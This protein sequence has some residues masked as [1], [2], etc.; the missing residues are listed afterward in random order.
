MRVVW[1]IGAL[2]LG[3]NGDWVKIQSNKVCT[4]G[5]QLPFIYDLSGGYGTD[6]WD[7]VSAS[8][9]WDSKVTFQKCKHQ[10][11]A[12]P[13]HCTKFMFANTDTDEF[14]MTV[15]GVKKCQ[16]RWQTLT[17]F[18][19]L[20][21][22]CSSYTDD[23]NFDVWE[24]IVDEDDH[25]RDC[26]LNEHAVDGVCTPCPAG[27]A[28]PFISHA[29]KY[30]NWSCN[31][32]YC[33]KDEHVSNGQCVACP[34]GKVRDAGDSALYGNTACDDPSDFCGLNQKSDGTTC[35]PCPAHT[36]WPHSRTLKS[37][38]W[39]CDKVYCPGSTQVVNGDCT[40]CPNKN[41][42]V[43]GVNTTIRTGGPAAWKGGPNT[44]CQDYGEFQCAF[45]QWSDGGTRTCLQCPQ[46]KGWGY[47]IDPARIDLPNGWGCQEK[48]NTWHTNDVEAEDYGT[49]CPSTHQVYNH[50]CFP[51]APG[52]HNSRQSGS[53]SEM[54]RE[55]VKCTPVTCGQNKHVHNHQCVACATNSFNWVG[56][57]DPRGANTACKTAS[58]YCGRNQHASN[59]QCVQCPV[60]THWPH[61]HTSKAT[62]YACQTRTCRKDYFFE[63][64]GCTQCWPFTIT[65]PLNKGTS[66]GALACA[67]NQYMEGHGCKN[68]P[69]GY[70]C[71]GK[72]KNVKMCPFHHKVVSHACVKCQ[73][74]SYN[75]KNERATSSMNTDCTTMT[76]AELAT[77]T[78]SPRHDQSF[79]GYD[80]RM[81]FKNLYYP[82]WWK[83]MY[84]HSHMRATADASVKAELAEA[85]RQTAHPTCEN[86]M[87]VT[88]AETDTTL[89]VKG[90]PAD[91][92]ADDFMDDANRGNQMKRFLTTVT[93]RTVE[94]NMFKIRSTR[95]ATAMF[96]AIEP[97]MHKECH[98]HSGLLRE[99]W[100]SDSQTCAGAF[101]DFQTTFGTSGCEGDRER[102]CC[103]TC[104]SKKS[105][106]GQLVHKL[107]SMSVAVQ[108]LAGV[109]CLLLAIAMGYGVYYY[110][111]TDGNSELVSDEERK[112]FENLP[113]D[114]HPVESRQKA[115]ELDEQ[116][117][118]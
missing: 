18:T 63:N 4:S 80:V 86:E 34:T 38:T 70:S 31:P 61:D 9:V 36:E 96:M 66:C 115:Y 67:S 104:L 68:C 39:T 112:S 92:D 65:G 64:N 88:M 113:S 45:N 30:P 14:C 111:C 103:E 42:T 93:G 91:D 87:T 44:V 25:S 5:N 79:Q 76:T 118:V 57:H 59:G 19:N 29:D 50:H 82:A 10:C 8:N 21:E 98:D 116:S 13:N 81:T 117:Q 107:K 22:S 73:A 106:V 62:D 71:D 51:C 97:N 15:D 110:C 89:V 69:T 75:F 49:R 23:A 85:I 114:K 41:I 109:A 55:N 11:N 43:N 35:S 83:A 33:A 84:S 37:L 28:W 7:P 46:G 16:C 77:M 105:L 56:G 26:A 99:Y 6:R 27:Y 102:V 94:F 90:F 100:Y 2:V 101:D 78:E 60:S 108:V 24:R 95:N 40:V 54:S 12:L 3:V 53:D 72:N 47:E 1:L 58:S 48:G 20:Q 74:G 17:G 32:Y 52:Y